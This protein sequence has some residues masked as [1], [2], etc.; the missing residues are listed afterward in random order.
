M[1][2]TH[3]TVAVSDSFFTAY[4]RL[5]KNQQAKVMNFVNKFRLDPTSGGINY[6]TLKNVKDRRLRS[7]RIDDD[8]RGIVCKPS[9]GN[10][11]LLL[12]VDKHDA[13]YQWARNRVCEINPLLGTVQV[14]CVDETVE[15]HSDEPAEVKKSIPV[16]LF[17]D[18]R[19]RELLALGVPEIQLEMIRGIESMAQLN[20]M[21][22]AVP[23]NVFTALTWLAQ[24]EP[25]AEVMAIL[26]ECGG[27]EKKAVDTEDFSKALEHPISR[28]HFQVDPSEDELAR[29]FNAP[30]EKWRVFLHPLQRK[31]VERD[32]NGP[33]RVL[34]GAGTG[35]T[36]VAMH[37]AAWLAGQL[38]SLSTG[39]I[40]FTT[41]TRNLA[42]D[43]EVN[44]KK[45]VSADQMKRIEVV[46][47][48]RW[49]SGF[50]KRSGYDHHIV[51]DDRTSELWK[52][53]LTLKPDDPLLPDSF[54]HQE[55][56]QI[57]QPHEIT[58]FA[59][60][61]KAPRTGR[62]VPLNRR[63]RK[64]IWPVFEEYQMLM[65]EHNLREPADAM[66]DARLLMEKEGAQLPYTAVIVDEAQDMGAQAFKLLRA[67]VPETA[68]DLF[69][70]G[71]AH[72]RIYNK[73]VVLGQ[74][75]IKIVGRSR[76][77]KVNYR[78]TEETRQWASGLMTGVTVD[79]LDGG[80][81]SLSGYVS[82]VHGTPPTVLHFDTMADEVSA[83]CDHLEQI[84]ETD[85]IFRSTCMVA[86]TN[87]LLD[88]YENALTEKGIPVYR[89]SGFDPEDRSQSGVRLATMHRVKGLEFDHVI[90]FGINKGTVPLPT[91]D[92]ISD[93][94]SVKEMAEAR[95]RS[96]LFV[97]AT[98]AK[99]TVM[100]TS[101]G[102]KSPYL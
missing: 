62:G 41:F 59:Q 81:D 94:V 64:Q 15:L 82:L 44:L 4:S 91:P 2:L 9:K 77:L 79:D 78:T 99:K 6:E 38:A 22:D 23:F 13:A 33:V 37:R 65:A 72:Q 31:L 87:Q 100:V 67:M 14:F 84:R 86:R 76:R 55:W 19:D 42:T 7:V 61:V 90:L 30:L 73:K 26:T 3:M 29:M 58:S 25:L 46:N 60:Y 93:D 57:I 92:L 21:A 71:D 5:P 16:G 95:E 43:I 35:K 34:G 24:G 85:D 68:N 53:A 32:W 52:T 40:L 98:R 36:V 80:K 63:Q 88:D 56:E 17:D 8:Y 97:A 48:D 75:G 69:I 101:Y 18:I 70:V 45:I 39:K 47:L 27:E 54:F 102:E 51:Y 89:L 83:I 10:V 20:E 49:V 50:L 1:A 28:Q 66:R 74:C 12:W 11:Y 96:L